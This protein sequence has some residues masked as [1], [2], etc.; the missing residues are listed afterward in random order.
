MTEAQ[1][2]S[3]WEGEPVRVWEGLWGVPDLTVLPHTD[4]TN[5]YLKRRGPGLPDYTTVIAEEQAAGRGRGGG[6]WSSQP[7]GLYLSWSVRPRVE[8]ATALI[9]LRVGIAVSQAIERLH[10]IS[11]GIKWPNDIWVG[12]QKLCGILC[13]G[14]PDGVIVGVGVNVR[15]TPIGPELKQPAIGLEEL[16][17]AHVS[18][19]T[20]AGAILKGARELLDRGAGVLRPDEL[21]ELESRDILAGNPVRVVPGPEGIAS[22]I[23][24]HGR[25]GVRSG[26]EVVRVSSGS[27]EFPRAAGSAGGPHTHQE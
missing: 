11:V 3:H 23:D 17:G 21:K 1:P 7:G 24:Q 6:S 10:G 9:P 16:V 18:R 19:G 5:L 12:S 14:G 22:G 20:L 8:A 27:I 2:L 15:V 26:D 25:L 13:E 4:S